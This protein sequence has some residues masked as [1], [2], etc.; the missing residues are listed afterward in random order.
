M[1]P[2]E[3]YVTFTYSVGVVAGS[4]DDAEHQARR[5]L[6]LDWASIKPRVELMIWA[7]EQPNNLIGG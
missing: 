5:Q 6:A 1:E 4:V 2:K 3:Y 7:S